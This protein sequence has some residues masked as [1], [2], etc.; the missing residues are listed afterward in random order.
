M[1]FLDLFLC[2][3][4][5]D[6]VSGSDWESIYANPNCNKDSRI[7]VGH[8]VAVEDAGESPSE[9]C[10]RVIKVK[11]ASFTPIL[12]YKGQVDFDQYL[13]CLLN[14]AKIAVWLASLIFFS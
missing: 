6:D 9:C 11:R 12:K 10:D 14:F 2:R 7:P 8:Y 13:L 5:A 4:V 1:E 3:V